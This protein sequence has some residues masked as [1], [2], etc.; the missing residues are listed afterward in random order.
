MPL[1]KVMLNSA[2]GTAVCTATSATFLT[3]T[4]TNI[5]LSCTTTANITMAASDRFYLWVGV[6]VT[7][8]SSSPFSGELDISLGIAADGTPHS[9]TTTVPGQNAFLNFSG[10]SAQRVSAVINGITGFTVGTTQVSLREL[11]TNQDQIFASIDGST[12]A[13]CKSGAVCDAFPLPATDNYAV[14]FN[15]TGTQTGSATVTV[16]TVP[17]D[18]SGTA[19]TLG[20]PVSVSTT[21]P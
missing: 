13:L 2:S 9:F 7:A 1:A 15:S 17:A 14:F 6:T 10:T 20:T 4:V 19:D 21:T 11:S 5:N 8:S 18:F 16:Y 3:V 12:Q